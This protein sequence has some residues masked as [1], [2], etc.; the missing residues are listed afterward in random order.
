[1]I[2]QKDTTNEYPHPT[3]DS[4]RLTAFK[5]IVGGV[6]NGVM[7]SDNVHVV[8]ILTL[9]V[10]MDVSGL[11]SNVS[12]RGSVSSNSDIS[13]PSSRNI[14]A[15]QLLPTVPENDDWELAS[16]DGWYCDDWSYGSSEDWPMVFTNLKIGQTIVEKLL[17]VT[18]LGCL[19]N[20]TV[21]EQR[22]S[23]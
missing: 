7:S 23:R 1:M 20:M 3:P 22:N 16:Q 17:G 13:T 19:V 10:Q 2:I 5:D 9:T 8:R 15:I 21:K 4:T 11:S 12:T 18:F 6:G 14:R